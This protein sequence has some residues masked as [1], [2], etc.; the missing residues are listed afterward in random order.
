MN[1]PCRWFYLKT[2]YTFYYKV[3]WV[4]LKNDTLITAANDESIF[5]ENL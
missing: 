3:Y 2:S 1:N 4:L 5:G